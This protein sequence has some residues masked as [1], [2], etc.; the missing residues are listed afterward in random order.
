[1]PRA[2][3]FALWITDASLFTAVKVRAAQEHVSMTTAVEG[4]IRRW[5][6]VSL[7]TEGVSPPRARAVKKAATVASPIERAV[8]PAN[9]LCKGCECRF[10]E[11]AVTGLHPCTNCAACMS[12]K[13]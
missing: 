3:K 6:G 12:F 7:A 13:G 8:T 9:R 10:D 11:H 5:L 4:A 1:M 2:T